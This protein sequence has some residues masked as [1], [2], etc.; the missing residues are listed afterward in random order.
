NIKNNYQKLH[1]QSLRHFIKVLNKNNESK[2]FKKQ[3]KNN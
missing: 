1:L 3:L 2:Y